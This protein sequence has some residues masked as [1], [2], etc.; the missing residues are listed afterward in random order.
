MRI[1]RIIAATLFVS[2]SVAASA[3]EITQSG[4]SPLYVGIDYETATIPTNPTAAGTPTTSR[5]Y[6]VRIDLRAPGIGFIATPHNGPLD[7]IS[8]TTSQFVTEQQVR[9]A[10]NTNFFAPCCNPF[11]EPKTVIGLLV[12]QG[13]IVSPPSFDP[14][15]SE[16]V[17][18]ITRHNDAMIA[19]APDVDLSNV[20]TA[21]AGSAIIVKDGVDVSASSPAEGDPLNPNPRTVVGL[22]RDGRFLYLAVIDGRVTGYSLGTTNAQSAALMLAIGCDSALNLDGGGSSEIVS[23]ATLGQPYILNNPSGGAERYD[24]AALGVFAKPLPGT[25]R[26]NGG[27]GKQ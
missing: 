20:Y 7:T 8:E 17:L 6:I 9:I 21:V 16:A 27:S 13:Q 11:P 19:E 25:Q 22:S 15:Q 4:F 26:G 18:A 10:I 3:A 24:A 5:A 1:L 14:L 2:T 23:A 12:S